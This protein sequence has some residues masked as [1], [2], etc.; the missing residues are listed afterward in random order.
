MVM[1]TLSSAEE[2]D[3]RLSLVSMNSKEE[4]IRLI[5][6]LSENKAYK[7][8]LLKEALVLSRTGKKRPKHKKTGSGC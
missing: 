4:N 2:R 8:V 5:K 7:F 3:N 6:L 1:T